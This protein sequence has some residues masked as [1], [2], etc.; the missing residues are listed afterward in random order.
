[1]GD[2]VAFGKWLQLKRQ[3]RG[4]SQTEAA[5][6]LD[7]LSKASI[8]GYENGISPVP[9]KRMFDLCEAYNIEVEEMLDKLKEYEP[10]I[11][12]KFRFLEDRFFQHFIKKVMRD[13]V[14]EERVGSLH[15]TNYHDAGGARQASHHFSFPNAFNGL[16]GVSQPRKRFTLKHNIY[17][18]TFASKISKLCLKP[19]ILCHSLQY[20]IQSSRLLANLFSQGCYMH[21]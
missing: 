5:K 7:F 19:T 20:S 4:I 13:R 15:N 6:K 9:I 8:V 11:Y 12:E 21:L 18:Q 10:Q 14:R 1:M 16:V 17:Y 2:R 3:E